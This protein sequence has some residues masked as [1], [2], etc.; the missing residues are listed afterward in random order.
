METER[1]WE[2]PWSFICKFSRVRCCTVHIIHVESSMFGVWIYL[3]A[4]TKGFHFEHPLQWIPLRKRDHTLFFALFFILFTY[5]NSLPYAVCYSVSVHTYHFD[6]WFNVTTSMVQQIHSS[7]LFLALC[8]QHSI[9]LK[10]CVVQIF[11][12]SVDVHSTTEF[13]LVQQNFSI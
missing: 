7:H 6:C 11:C 2:K 5:T 9:C 1:D 8:L 4:R 10:F 3:L 12:R 13:N